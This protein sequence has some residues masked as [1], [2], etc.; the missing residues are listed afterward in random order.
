MKFYR[1]LEKSFSEIEKIFDEIS[2][3]NFI[4]SNYNDLCLYHFGL[5]T[6]IRN[7]IL[8]EKSE[9]YKIF[10]QSGIKD[11]DEIS[12]IIIKLFYFYKK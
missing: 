4:N 6:F 7:N 1:E 12:S 2:M 8:Q 3:F 11:K 5:G 10:L 9:I